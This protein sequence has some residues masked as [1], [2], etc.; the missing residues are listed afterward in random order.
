MLD[1]KKVELRS[2]PLQ[3]IGEEDGRLV[4]RAIVYNSESV[5]FGGWKEIILPGAIELDPDLYLDYD[6][7]SKYILGRTAN[8]TL[9]VAQDSEGIGFAATPPET[10]FTADV[11]EMMRGGYVK[12][13]SFSFWVLDDE[14]TE[15]GGVVRRVIKRAHVFALTIT[16]I[17][18]YP[19][20]SSEARDRFAAM[21]DASCD[22]GGTLDGVEAE[23]HG[24]DAEA[25]QEE[26]FVAS[27]F[28]AIRIK[29]DDN[30]ASTD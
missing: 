25:Q 24:G 16:G 21:R 30:D 26:T 22:T 19:E 1:P 20:T 11:R 6:H 2:A 13:C 15:E 14:W 9:D 29:D 3:G 8:G 5:D 28:G 4:G 12:G 27:P 23:P 17:P 10:S 7:D 18:A